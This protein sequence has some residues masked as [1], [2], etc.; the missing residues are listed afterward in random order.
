MNDRY[1]I[2]IVYKA[3][4]TGGA[5]KHRSWSEIKITTVAPGQMVM[6]CRGAKGLLEARPCLEVGVL[7]GVDQFMFIRFS[8]RIEGWHLFTKVR[9]VAFGGGWPPCTS[10]GRGGVRSDHRHN[11]FGGV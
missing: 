10:P 5:S 6:H 8:D 7:P 11:P 4:L 2:V 3:P 1:D 9:T